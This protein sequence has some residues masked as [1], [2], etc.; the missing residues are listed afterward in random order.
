MNASRSPASVPLALPPRV[1]SQ[2]AARLCRRG[3][4]PRGDRCAGFSLVEL[5]VVFFIISVVAALAVPGLKHVQTNARSAAVINDLRVFSSGLQ[6][7][8]HDRSDW[9]PATG[10]PGELPAGTQ[11]Y[12]PATAW[13]QPSPIGGAYTWATNSLQ[14]GERYR[15]AI[16]ISNTATSKVT[17]DRQQLVDIDRKLDDGNL[18]TG[19]F[20]L[21]YRNQPVFVIEH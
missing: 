11:T 9:P 18:E 10:T 12:L 16:L 4:Q 13:T 5:S 3:L 1:V 21:G 19:N 2:S 17:S 8:A 6:S 15:A 14:Q 7:Y 20:R